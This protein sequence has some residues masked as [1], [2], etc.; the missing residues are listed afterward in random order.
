MPYS[1][2]RPRLAASSRV[3]IR[4]SIE[5][6]DLFL[7]SGDTPK[8]LGHALHRAPVRD[9]KLT[10]R[11]SRAQLDRMIEIAARTSG[12]DRREQRSLDTFIRFLENMSDRF[13]D[14]AGESPS[15]GAE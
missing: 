4:L 15:D 9:G 2:Q 5:Q 10:V 1:R 3:S 13:E 7:R 6:R 12:R 11:V 8:D 14:E